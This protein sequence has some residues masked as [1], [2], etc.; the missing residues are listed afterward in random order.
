M[1]GREKTVCGPLPAVELLILSGSTQWR[2]LY[3]ELAKKKHTPNPPIG[4]GG[5]G[6][7][8]AQGVPH[9]EARSEELGAVKRVRQVGRGCAIIWPHLAPPAAAKHMLT[10]PYMYSKV[11]ILE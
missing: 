5:R 8:L 9:C 7:E 1:G 6:H 4:Q 11:D 2:V 10:Q 3:S